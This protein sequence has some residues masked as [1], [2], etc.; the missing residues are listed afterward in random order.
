M[1]CSQLGV[2]LILIMA[3]CNSSNDHLYALKEDLA[4]WLNSLYSLNIDVGTFMPKLETGVTLCRSV[5]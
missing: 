5:Q 1:L 4:E 3:K 2:S